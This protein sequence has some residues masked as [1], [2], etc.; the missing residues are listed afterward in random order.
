MKLKLFT[1]KFSE[2]G[3]GFNDEPLQKFIAD[4]EVIE[5]A[6]HFFVHEKTP[7]LTVVLSYRE[8]SYNEMHKGGRYPDYRRDLDKQEL[9]AFEALRA[10][11]AIRAG[12]E[13]VPP[14]IIANN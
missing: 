7:Y 2:S 12:Q 14:Y 6:N 4:K 5:F 10:W 3:G 13:G 1:F 9:V 8:L 11:R